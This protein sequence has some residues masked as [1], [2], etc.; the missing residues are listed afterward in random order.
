MTIQT[1]A[2]PGRNE[3]CRCGSGRKYKHCC[4][5]KDEKKDAT[6]RKKAAAEP[7]PAPSEEAPAAT[8][9]RAEAKNRSA[10]E[11]GRLELD[12]RLRS[13]LAD[14]TQGRWR[15]RD[16]VSDGTSAAASLRM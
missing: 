12:P 7:E 14:A 15:L 11:G 6:A 8:C 16:D 9:A 13:A 10:V 4:L 5:A 1:D 2:R 3:P